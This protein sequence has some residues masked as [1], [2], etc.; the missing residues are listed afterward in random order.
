MPLQNALILNMP[1]QNGYSHRCHHIAIFFSEYAIKHGKILNCPCPFFHNFCRHTLC[2][3]RRSSHRL[4]CCTQ[5]PC[6]PSPAVAAFQ[7]GKICLL[8]PLLV[9]VASD[10]YLLLL[11]GPFMVVHHSREEWR[12]SKV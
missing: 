7:P 5:S 11:Q 10:F 9:L 1:M 4:C 3:L 12:K 6:S 8:H 2:V